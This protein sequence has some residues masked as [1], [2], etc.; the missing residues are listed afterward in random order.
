M[1]RGDCL[2]CAKRARGQFC[3]IQIGHRRGAKGH[4][5]NV[6]ADHFEDDAEP[7]WID[8]PPV[9]T[10][11]VQQVQCSRISFRY[12]VFAIVAHPFS[13]GPISS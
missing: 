13:T 12:K 11:E 5:A 3:A 2:S 6:A 7:P 1:A 10:T 4:V 9:L 8:R